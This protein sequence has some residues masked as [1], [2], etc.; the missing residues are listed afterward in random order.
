MTINLTWI[1]FSH[2]FCNFPSLLF[3]HPNLKDFHIRCIISSVYKEIKKLQQK[4]ESWV[5]VFSVLCSRIYT[6]YLDCYWNACTRL[7][8]S[9]TASF[10]LLL[11]IHTCI[12]KSQLLSYAVFM[13]AFCR[14][15][16]KESGIYNN[17][18]IWIVIE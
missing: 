4:H 3:S 6:Q 9:V 7:E 2:N 12:S 18:F 17:G 11:I 10:Q 14:I 8:A 16:V 13:D 1:N 5:P 15:L